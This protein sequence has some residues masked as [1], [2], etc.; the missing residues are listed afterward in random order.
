MIKKSQWK[1]LKTWDNTNSLQED[2]TSFPLKPIIQNSKHNHIHSLFYC[3]FFHQYTK[4]TLSPTTPNSPSL[5]PLLLFHHYHHQQP[6]TPSLA[7]YN[8]LTNP[9]KSPSELNDP[10]PPLPPPLSLPKVSLNR[11]SLS[12]NP[13]YTNPDIKIPHFYH[14]CTPTTS[15]SMKGKEIN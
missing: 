3:G 2:N 12:R 5:I 11:G 13:H 10:P 1:Y 15:T 14:Q 6:S 7:Q 8:Y 4:T 9:T